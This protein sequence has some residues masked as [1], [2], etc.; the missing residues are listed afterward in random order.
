VGDSL[1]S[2]QNNCRAD[3]EMK[4]YKYTFPILFLRDVLEATLITLC[5]I[6]ANDLEKN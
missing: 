3:A 4:F 1:M 2:N 5:Y 6:P